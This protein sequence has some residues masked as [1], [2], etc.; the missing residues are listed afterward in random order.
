MT[1]KMG[2]CKMVWCPA[3]VV[4]KSPSTS[5]KMDAMSNT[6]ING[7]IVH[8]GLLTNCPRIYPDAKWDGRNTDYFTG[9]LAD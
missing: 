9:L 8:N 5:G 3:T 4:E 2:V 6:G 1:Q 7:D